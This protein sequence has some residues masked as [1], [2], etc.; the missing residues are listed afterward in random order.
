MST[1]KEIYVLTNLEGTHRGFYNS[2]EDLV[3]GV[4]LW[5]KQ[6]PQETLIYENW[7]CHNSKED[8][9]WDYAYVSTH[10][11]QRSRQLADEGGVDYFP[12]RIGVNLLVE[13]TTMKDKLLKL[14]LA[15]I[16]AL[17]TV[18][19]A[20]HENPIFTAYVVLSF[21]VL[22][23]ECMW[24]G[25]SM[26]V[27]NIMFGVALVATSVVYWLDANGCDFVQ[28]ALEQEENKDE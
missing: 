24:I 10:E 2:R 4:N 12:S 17:R 5:M 23:I 3:A 26:T 19:I 22:A 7:Y 28:A 14:T 21:Y 20:V 16:K 8:I 13:E 1:A 6:F 15:F 27:C 25:Y 11:E 9:T 18:S